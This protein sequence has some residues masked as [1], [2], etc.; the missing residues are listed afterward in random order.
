LFWPTL[1]YI[2]RI[3]SEGAVST[4]VSNKQDPQSGFP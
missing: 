3:S 2:I 1:Y 4:P